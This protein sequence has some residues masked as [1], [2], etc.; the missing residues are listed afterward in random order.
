MDGFYA[1]AGCTRPNQVSDRGRRWELPVSE[2][3]NR[4]P[5]ETETETPGCGSKTT[6]MHIYLEAWV[7]LYRGEHGP[8]LELV[9]DGSLWLSHAFVT[10]HNS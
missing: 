4:E 9:A 3:A 1:I 10:G 8:Q 2:I 5:T 7:S 6:R